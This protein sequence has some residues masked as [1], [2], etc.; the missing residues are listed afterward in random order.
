VAWSPDG[1]RIAYASDKA[2][3]FDI[4][5]QPVAGGEAT[6]LTTSPDNDTQPAWAPDGSSIAFRSERDGGGVFVVP[7]L[8]GAARRLTTFGAHPAWMPDSRDISV[9]LGPEGG[10]ARA[11]LVSASG[12]QPPR[13]ILSEFLQGG[14][15]QWMAPHPEGRFSVI[16]SHRPRG[17]GFY[18]LSGDGRNLTVVKPPASLLASLSE[19]EPHPEQR[20]Q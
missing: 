9:R 17:F 20:F 10:S 2:G 18:T 13:E 14:A 7:A 3:N 6:Q 12:D 11:F 19:G 15:W 8:G 1:Q 4:W 16:G 5:V